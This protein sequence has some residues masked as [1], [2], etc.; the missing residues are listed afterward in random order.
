MVSC[1]TATAVSRDDPRMELRTVE[2]LM[3]LLELLAER[4]ARCVPSA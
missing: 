4:H 2:E 3:D 1:R